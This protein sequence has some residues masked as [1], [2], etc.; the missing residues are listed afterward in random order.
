MDNNKKHIAPIELLSKYL[1]GEA[2]FDE[3]Q[4]IDSWRLSG[5]ENK[6]EFDAFAKLWN[7]SGQVSTL[8]NINLDTEWKR[9]E[10]AI[11]PARA[12]TISFARILQVAA[13]I[14]VLT[15]LSFIGY[16]FT[17]V[18]TEKSPA[19]GLSIIGLP[20]GSTVSLNAGSKIT[21]KK[22]FGTTHRNLSLKGEGYFEVAKNAGTPFSVSVNEATVRVV[23]T[24]FNIKA[25]KNTPEVKVLVTDGTVKLYESGQPQKQIILNAGESGSYRSAGKTIQKYTVT[26]LNDIS[27]KTREIVFYNTPLIEV[28][29]VLSNTYHANIVIGE[30]IK[31]CP[32]TVNFTKQELPSVLKVLKST[33]NLKITIEGNKIKISGEGC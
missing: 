9:L 13:T 21:Y 5:E 2:S 25:Y 20:D 32:I 7:A 26:N 23:G 15:V 18:K 8:S 24:K 22:G 10:N 16:K 30:E 12:K 17:S 3:K 14:A 19:D 27:W 1:A 29:E 33:L 4:A 28:A 31:D 6:K 11:S